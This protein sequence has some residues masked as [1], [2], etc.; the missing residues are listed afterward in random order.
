MVGVGGGGVVLACASFHLRKFVWECHNRRRENFAIR[1]RVLDQKM[2]KN[3][4]KQAMN[5]GK[6][7]GGDKF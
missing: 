7:G 3:A 4:K 6:M 1:K 5:M 2:Q